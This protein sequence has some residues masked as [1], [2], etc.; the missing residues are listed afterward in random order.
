MHTLSINPTPW[1]AYSFDTGEAALNVIYVP[2]VLFFVPSSFLAIVIFLAHMMLRNAI[3]HCGYEVFPSTRDG[4][5]L[6]DWLTT[7]THHDLHHAQAGWNYGLYFTWWDRLMG[8][9]HPLYHET[10]AEAVRKPLD[11]SAVAALG[12]KVRAG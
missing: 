3:G 7:V 9:Q 10:F 4:H 5:P 8:T 1:A 2:I 6:F 12:L 11:G